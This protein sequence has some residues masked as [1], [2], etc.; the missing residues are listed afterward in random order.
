MANE[1]FINPT[2]PPDL[3]PFVNKDVSQSNLAE[4]SDLGKDLTKAPSFIS[5]LPEDKPQATEWNVDKN[6]TVQGQFTDIMKSDSPVF[7]QVREQVVR[8]HAA[9]G[10]QNSLMAARSAEMA[11]AEVGFKIASQ[12][13]ATFARSGEFNA[14]MK[15]QFGLAEQQFMHNALLSEQN[16]K[17]GVM[18]L[19]E[20]QMADLEKINA[21]MKSR[22]NL[23]GAQGVIDLNLESAKHMNV[24]SQMD[25][26]YGQN[27]ES[28]K[29]QQSQALERMD[30]ESSNSLYQEQQKFGWQSQLSYM[31]EVGQNGRMLMNTVGA[32]G[33]NPNISVQQAQAAISDAVRQYNAVN[34]QLAA[35]YTVPQDP[36]STA[37]GYLNFSGHALGPGN[38]APAPAP[39][40]QPVPVAAPAAAPAPAIPQVA[41]PPPVPGGM[42]TMVG[43]V[44]SVNKSL[45]G[46]DPAYQRAWNE[47]VAG[48]QAQFGRGFNKQ[49]DAAAI[50]QHLAALY[51]QYRR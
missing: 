46:S 21:D 39:S 47:V 45:Y 42:V 2:T 19:R 35:T 1:Q 17:Q 16:F 22:L 14:A 40:F 9:R 15:N 51:Q 6:Q 31:S 29:L 49:S 41:A 30:R 7:K 20:Q 36:T 38:P 32:I 10:G 5:E 27:M 12:D 3:T 24:L 26:A 13:A 48:H 8:E 28:L 37:R 25:K 33:S 34:A 18:M 43:G 4:N 23:M 50:E 44:P 11:V